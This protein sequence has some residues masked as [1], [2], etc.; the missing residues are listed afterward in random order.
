MPLLLGPQASL[1]AF[2]RLSAPK[3]SLVIDEVERRTREHAIGTV[4]LFLTLYFE[5][6][7]AGRTPGEVEEH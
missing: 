2:C 6:I 7:A 3:P 1:L 5:T 4:L